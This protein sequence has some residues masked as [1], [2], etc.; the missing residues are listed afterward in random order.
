LCDASGVD[1]RLLAWMPHFNGHP[2]R[3]ADLEAP[4]VAV[5]DHIGPHA[6]VA[7]AAPSIGY[8][9]P[10]MRRRPDITFFSTVS[11]RGKALTASADYVLAINSIPPADLVAKTEQPLWSAAP[12]GFH[13]GLWPGPAR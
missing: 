7:V 6:R 4:L 12:P 2:L 3:H 8:V 13:E 11:P 1:R 5:G 10:L 9:Y